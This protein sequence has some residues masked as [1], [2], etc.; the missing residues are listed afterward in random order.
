M[1][2][3]LLKTKILIV[4]TIF[5]FSTTSCDNKEDV[6]QNNTNNVYRLNN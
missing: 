2:K 4:T 5:L 6:K 3:H 1:T